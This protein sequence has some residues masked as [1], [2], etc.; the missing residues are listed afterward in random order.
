MANQG[1]DGRLTIVGAGDPSGFTVEVYRSGILRETRLGKPAP[2][3]A[4]GNF[5]VR[6]PSGPAAGQTLVVRLY[7]V[8]HRLIYESDPIPKV[9]DFVLGHDIVTLAGLAHGWR[10]V[11][12]LGIL[13]FSTGNEI[14][15]FIDNETAWRTLGDDVRA[16]AESVHLS[17]LHFEL[18]HFDPTLF[19]TQGMFTA[20]SPDPPLMNVPTTGVRLEERLKDAG[21]RGLDVRVLM[22]D[23][24]GLGFP[25]DTFWRVFLYFDGTPVQVK[26]FDRFLREGAMHGKTVVIDGQTLYSIGSPLLQEYFGGSSHAIDDPRRGIM[27][28]PF[29]AIKVP[30]HDVSLRIRGPT[31]AD[32]DYVFTMLW[33]KAPGAVGPFHPPTAAPHAVQIALTL[34]GKTIAGMD[35]GETTILEGYL[36]AIRYA[37]HFIYLEN[38]YFTEDAIAEALIRILK[39]KPALQVIMVLNPKLDLVPYSTWQRTLIDRIIAELGP[40]KRQQIG[41]FSLWTHE[42][43]DGVS[44]VVRN[45]V[46]S[47]VGVV[48]DKWATVGSANLDGL[49]LNTSQYVFYD[50]IPSHRRFDRTKRA[51]EVNAMVYNVDGVPPSDFPDTLRR[52]LWA[53]HLGYGN[54]NHPDLLNRP[55]DGWLGLWRRVA[56]AKGASLNANPPTVHPA[57]ALEGPF[58]K[59]ELRTRGIS[60]EE[61]YLARMGINVKLH[62]VLEEIRSF[63]FGTGQWVL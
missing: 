21:D 7:D 54:P 48:D 57:R 30:I 22:N 15:P 20:F 24:I 9:T 27:W 19:P 10:I 23:F 58:D 63:D 61:E 45:Y 26:G 31:A 50:P 55:A 12:A 28:F 18:D 51:I 8:V 35:A 1:V 42:I 29:N 2:T 13:L 38:Q 37:E 16:A 25:F 39:F 60:G 4:G 44:R 49:S 46:H 53:E 5:S 56:A 6:Y 40:D 34:P 14:E 17:Q 43:A 59:P 11:S 52:L 62:T 3:D 33:N 36:R 32:G 41:F 47:K